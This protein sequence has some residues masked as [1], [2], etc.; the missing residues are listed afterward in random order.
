MTNYKKEY[1]ILANKLTQY[2][3][4]REQDRIRLYDPHNIAQDK[5]DTAVYELI[6][7]IRMLKRKEHKFILT[8]N[9]RKIIFEIL[10]NKR[11]VSGLSRFEYNYLS[12]IG[13][14]Y[15][16]K[17]NAEFPCYPNIMDIAQSEFVKRFAIDDHRIKLF[18]YML[19][20]ISQCNTLYGLSK[21]TVVI[22]GSFIDLSVT[23]PNDIDIIVLLPER[24]FI[25]EIKNKKVE[26]NIENEIEQYVDVE[27][28]PENINH[29]SYM[30][31]ELLTLLGN[32]PNPPGEDNLENV[33]F[34]CRSVYRF[35]YSTFSYF[36]H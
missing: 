20:V 1:D 25:D 35:P 13:W 16:L 21:T 6:K 12:F 3:N 19:K 4:L 36:I 30:T 34:S 10:E 33:A 8:E 11:V 17:S 18:Q 5:D 9:E 29:N 2:Q 22:G 24:K 14:K 15:D 32:S 23:K 31:Y 7:D 27:F 28:L 26:R